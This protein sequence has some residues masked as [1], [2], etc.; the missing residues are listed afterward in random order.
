MNLEQ[1]IDLLRN[2]QRINSNITH[3]KSFSARPP[4]YVDFPHD[5]NPRLVASLNETGI[6]RLYSHQGEAITKV[7]NGENIVV[8]TPTAS[9]K[10]LC[11]NIPVLDKIIKC[12]SSFII[13]FSYWRNL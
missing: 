10:T 13:K 2:D 5:L 3:W 7:I 9:G 6:T 11:Y 4:K 8:V 1:I 12:V